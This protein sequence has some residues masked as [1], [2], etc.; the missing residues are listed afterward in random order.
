MYCYF[1]YCH[2]ICIHAL[3]CT[4]PASW[5]PESN[6]HLIYDESTED[7]AVTLTTDN[8]SMALTFLDPLTEF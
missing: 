7:K 4:N 8:C 2:F 6:K 3:F 5:L 1:N